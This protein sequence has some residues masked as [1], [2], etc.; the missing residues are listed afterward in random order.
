[1]G[2]AVVADE[3]RTLAQRSAEA[4][5]DTAALIEASLAA[6]SDGAHKVGQVTAAIAA[7]TANMH[8]VK[9]LVHEMSHASEQQAQGIAQVSQAIVEMEQVTQQTA[10]SAEE[11]AAAS[12]ELT[13]QVGQTM[14]LVHGLET[15]V[16]GG[17]E[18][19]VRPAEA[20]ARPKPRLRAA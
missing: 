6:S 11:G 12:E 17:G 20:A 1:M 9:G 19:R 13:G 15:M 7:V 8:Q 4:A 16:G 5:R 10:A 3:V 2:F 18:A 14:E